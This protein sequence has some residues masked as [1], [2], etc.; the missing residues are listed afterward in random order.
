MTQRHLT[1]TI[2]L[3]S[4]DT[5]RSI[6]VFEYCING[7]PLVTLANAVAAC[8]APERGQT[9]HATGLVL[10]GVL[11]LIGFIGATLQSAVGKTTLMPWLH[12]V[13]TPIILSL[14][15]GL[16]VPVGAEGASLA[17]MLVQL[18]AALL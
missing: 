3:P 15:V 6:R 17:Q 11:A 16:A 7:L 8:V 10:M 4:A 18:V 2:P 14:A 9:I 13:W 12:E 5:F 1:L